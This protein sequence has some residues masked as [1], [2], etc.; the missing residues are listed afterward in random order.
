MHQNHKY[1][2][3]NYANNNSAFYVVSDGKTPYVIA[4][5]YLAARTVVKKVAKSQL[6]KVLKDATKALKNPIP[7]KRFHWKDHPSKFRREVGKARGGK[8]LMAGLK[9]NLRLKLVR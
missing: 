6:Q 2:S 9:C 7:R 3:Y 5:I 4:A 1:Y 8:S